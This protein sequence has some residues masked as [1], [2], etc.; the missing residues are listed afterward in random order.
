MKPTTFVILALVGVVGI[1][2]WRSTRASAAIAA[3]PLTLPGR[4]VKTATGIVRN[5][6]N[7]EGQLLGHVPVIGGTLKDVAN[8]PGKLLG[9]IGL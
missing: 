3:T 8:V 5:V 2:Y 6:G 7:A 4:A 1:L 9:Y